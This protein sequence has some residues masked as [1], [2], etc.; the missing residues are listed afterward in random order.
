MRHRVL[1]AGP[2]VV[3]AFLVAGCV[4]GPSPTAPATTAPL[5]PGPVASLSLDE[6]RAEITELA[7]RSLTSI[8]EGSDGLVVQLTPDAE[9]IARE[10]Y[11]RF[12][13][14]VRVGVGF[15]PFP[16]PTDVERSC[17]W[18]PDL[19]P[20][21]GLVATIEMPRLTIVQ[22]QSFNAKVRLTNRQPNPLGLETSSNL[23]LYL[24]RAGDDLPIGASAGGLL[25]MGW[26]AQ[27]LPGESTEVQGGGGTASC[28]LSLGYMVPPGAYQARALVD[29]V[30]ETGE[31]REIRHFFG[32]P[33][34]VEVVAP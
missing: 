30:H 26:G 2:V 27:L 11:A 10:I 20:L 1:A 4:T 31:D 29:Y 32:E 18:I 19:T 28:D 33:L 13:G 12:G 23:S 7:G 14:S 25:G 8:G 34:L 24:F 9:A 21:P 5:T 17:A 6:L 15:F 3:A 22:G 16:P